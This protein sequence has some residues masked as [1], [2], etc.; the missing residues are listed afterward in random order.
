MANAIKHVRWQKGPMASVAYCPFCNPPRPFL[1]RVP[2]GRGMGK[3]YGLAAG[4]TARAK[5]AAHIKELH[6]EKLK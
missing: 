2:K 1:V 4:S 5:V 6:A 3:G